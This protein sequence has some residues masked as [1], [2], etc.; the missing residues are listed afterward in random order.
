MSDFILEVWT[1]LA[2]SE[3]RKP[4]DKSKNRS[5]YKRHFVLQFLLQ[6]LVREQVKDYQ[7]IRIR[8]GIFPIP[9]VCGLPMGRAAG[10]HDQ[11]FGLVRSYI[12]GH[13]RRT[14]MIF[15][16]R[17]FNSLVFPRLSILFFGVLY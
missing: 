3:S 17:L 5:H 15:R 13:E 9:T 10:A 8:Q 2:N 1:D 12:Y 6:M 14:V 7:I 11:N 16:L 4:H